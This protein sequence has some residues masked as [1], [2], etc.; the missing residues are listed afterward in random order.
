MLNSNLP[1]F[2][3]SRIEALW[4]PSWADRPESAITSVLVE[5]QERSEAAAGVISVFDCPPCYDLSTGSSKSIDP[6]SPQLLHVSPH[7]CCHVEPFPQWFLGRLSCIFCFGIL[8]HLSGS[9]LGYIKVSLNIAVL[10]LCFG[11]SKLIL[12][13]S[14]T[15]EISH[16][17][18]YID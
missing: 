8:L 18:N 10:M 3:D 15:A 16:S 4:L 9:G 12:W 1:P 7:N 13:I 6:Y 5:P 14:P 11:T 17:G 2:G